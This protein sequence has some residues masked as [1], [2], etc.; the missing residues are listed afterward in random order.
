MSRSI[1]VAIFLSAA[2]LSGCATEQ[3]SALVAEPTDAASPDTPSLQDKCS[4]VAATGDM[5]RYCLEVGP[6]Q[7]AFGSDGAG[8]ATAAALKAD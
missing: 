8:P 1:A 2:A 3:R 7:A 6:Q 5:Y 4:R